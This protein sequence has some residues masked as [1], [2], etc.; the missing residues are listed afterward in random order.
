[1]QILQ[2][3]RFFNMGLFVLNAKWWGLFFTSITIRFDHNQ[4]LELAA[5]CSG[6]DFIRVGHSR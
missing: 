2:D 6:V 1:M 5:A 4:V 3:F